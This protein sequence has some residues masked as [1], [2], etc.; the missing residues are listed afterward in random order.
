VLGIASVFLL[1]SRLR[2]MARRGRDRDERG[3]MNSEDDGMPA[4]IEQELLALD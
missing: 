4:R 1:A 2:T 3:S